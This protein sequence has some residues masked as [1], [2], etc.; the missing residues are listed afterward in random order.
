MRALAILALLIGA[1]WFTGIGLVTASVNHGGDVDESHRLVATT[2]LGDLL[3]VGSSVQLQCELAGNG[4]YLATS[5]VTAFT[6]L[7]VTV[8]AAQLDTP[9]R[10]PFTE[11]C[12]HWRARHHV[13]TIS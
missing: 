11:S 2:I 4:G 5:A 12:D 6:Y 7:T 8:S 3:P 1:V 9:P 10:G 13:A